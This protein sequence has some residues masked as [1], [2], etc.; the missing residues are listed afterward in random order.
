MIGWGVGCLGGRLGLGL[1]EGGLACFF[2]LN[3]KVVCAPC[4]LALP[5]TLRGGSAFIL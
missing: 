2:F 5:V 4:L 1:G 3:A